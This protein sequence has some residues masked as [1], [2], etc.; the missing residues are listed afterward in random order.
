MQSINPKVQEW[1]KGGL[2]GGVVQNFCVLYLAHPCPIVRR[3]QVLIQTCEGL[4]EPSQK[5]GLLG[6]VTQ[7]LIYPR[8]SH[9]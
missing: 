5:T 8:S 3:D 4:G 6:R 9:V 7:V 1:L 2:R